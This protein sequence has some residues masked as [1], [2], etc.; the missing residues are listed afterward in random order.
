MD[1]TLKMLQ[2]PP[3]LLLALLVIASSL[4]GSICTYF[5]K[6]YI[7][8]KILGSHNEVTGYVF[9]SV[10][11]LYGLLLAFVI[12]LVWDQF[13]GAQQT[14]DMEGSVAKGLYRNIVYYPDSESVKIKTIY[15]AYVK[16]VVDT[17]YPLIAQGKTSPET[18]RHF[19]EVF[20]AIE[21]L[22]PSADYKSR[23]VEEMFRNLNSL[24]TY[25]SLRLLDAGS[26]IPL[27]IWIPLLLGGFITMML[28]MILNIENRRL[29]VFINGLLGAFIGM[30]LF[31]I[32]LIDHPFTGSMNIQ[33]KG[34]LQILSMDQRPDN[35]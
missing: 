3:I 1:L 35:L 8:I 34:Y 4:I 13:N 17:E 14:A 11:G 20:K 6:K 16:N 22:N 15:M 33:P 32:I 9:G 10:A 12:F 30:I 18:I 29:H 21:H 19:D 27:I 23:R 7:K 5:F 25:R 28:A 24:S 26:D 2:M 31:L